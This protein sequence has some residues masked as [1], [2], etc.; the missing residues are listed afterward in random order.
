MRR[1]LPLC[2]IFAAA[3]LLLAGVWTALAAQTPAV[4]ATPDNSTTASSANTAANPQGK[5]TETF[6]PPPKQ[7][8]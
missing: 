8:P 5:W 2:A 3:S 7:S 4:P 1:V 6:G